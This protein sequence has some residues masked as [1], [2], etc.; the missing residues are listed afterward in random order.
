MLLPPTATV[1]R[2]GMVE[3]L[4]RPQRGVWVDT[5][6][7][8]L[9][10]AHVVSWHGENAAVAGTQP[11]KMQAFRA[12]SAHLAAASGT[13]LLGGDLNTWRDPVQLMS[14]DVTDAYVDE[15]AFVGPDPEHRL[16]DA[17][18]TL[19]AERGELVSSEPD[20]RSRCHT[21]CGA[22]PSTGSTGSS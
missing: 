12:V 15:H 20:V 10:R 19:L 21:D 5:D 14:P 3:G 8:G 13:V 2:A 18:R 11:R 4:P 6:V 1:H 9:G 17:W 22:G 16:F 7:P